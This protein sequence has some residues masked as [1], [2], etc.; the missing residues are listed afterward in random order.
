MDSV[1]LAP[2]N[3]VM[4]STLGKEPSMEMLV[5]GNAGQVVFKMPILIVPCVN[6]EAI[7]PLQPLLRA[8]NVLQEAT[9]QQVVLF[10]NMHAMTA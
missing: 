2:R 8:Q 1:K 5:R 6:Q 3:Q 7:L 10:L 4:L 9:P